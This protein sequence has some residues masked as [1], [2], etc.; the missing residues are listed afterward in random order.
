MLNG[1][2]NKERIRGKVI[3]V[4][5]SAAGL[6]DLYHT[7]FDAQFPGMKM[8][9]VMVEN[10]YDGSLIID[11]VWAKATKYAACLLTGFVISLLFVFVNS[12][13]LVL[14]GAILWIGHI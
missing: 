13:F 5:S 4:G 8:H 2:V 10:I 7:I 11:P 14:I 9:S 3:F 12:A 6:K 1:S